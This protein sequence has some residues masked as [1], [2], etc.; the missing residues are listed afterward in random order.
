MPVCAQLEGDSFMPESL[1]LG[2]HGFAVAR[3]F[4]DFEDPFF[5]C[6]FGVRHGGFAGRVCHSRRR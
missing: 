3:T 6:F 4:V 5:R 2:E 1:W